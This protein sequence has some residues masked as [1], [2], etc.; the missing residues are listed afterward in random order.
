MSCYEWEEG[1]IIIPSKEYVSVRRWVITAHNDMEKKCLDYARAV[2]AELLAR[3]KRQRNVNW[4]QA[5]R[6]LVLGDRSLRAVRSLDDEERWRMH[7][8]VH[9]RIPPSGRPLKPQVKQLDLLPLTATEVRV[10]EASITFENAKRTVSWSVPDNNHACETARDHPVG[11]ALF[12]RLK[13]VK[14]TRGSGGVIVGN[15]EYASED[16]SVGGGGN[17]ANSV[18]GPLGSREVGFDANWV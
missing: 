2:H 14:W 6:D 8:L 10:G 11:R 12:A 5:L 16:R 13:R 7:S 18:F 17:T 3:T 1:A 15:D 9:D 4:E